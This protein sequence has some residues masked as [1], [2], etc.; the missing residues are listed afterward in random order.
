MSGVRIFVTGATGF[1][2]Q[3][4]VERLAARG[5]QVVAWV[6]DVGRARRLLGERA[7]L[8]TDVAD[9]GGCAG[10]VNLAGSPVAVRWTDA[11]RREIR[12]SRIDLTQQLTAAMAKAAR[13]PTVLVSASAVGVYGDRGDEILDESAPAG[14]DFLARICRDWESAAEV[15]RAGGVRVVVPR[16]GIVLGRAGGALARLLPPFRAGVGG[17]L[18]GGKQWMAWIHVADLVEVLVAALDNARFDGVM[19]ATAPTPVTNRDFSRALGHALHR[20]SFMPLPGFAMKL[21]FGEAA[22][23]LLAGQ[24]ALPRRLETLG[25]QF[26]FPTIESALA[27]LVRK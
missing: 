11:R 24:R 23:A 4:L 27:D 12:A 13:R 22:A 8:V 1:I 14:D 21:A 7:L 18:A 19:N 25:F 3:A 10:V 2:G 6:R 20:P 5:D 16:I 15:A 26:K 17:P 9:V